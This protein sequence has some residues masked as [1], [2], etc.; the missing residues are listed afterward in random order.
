[1]DLSG[2]KWPLII[3]VIVA[4]GWLAT[5]GGINWM[6]GNF[7]KSTPGI[8]AEKDKADEAGLSRVGGYLLIMWR[9]EK[10][11]NVLDTAIARYPNGAN[12]YHNL[13]RIARC[14]DRLGNYQAKINILRELMDDDAHSIDGRVPHND[15]LISQADRLIEMYDLR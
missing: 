2:L 13:Y 9:W 10:A 14:E 11:R 15:I 12:Y 3:L 5:S 4:L 1:M 6:V 7:T 8:D